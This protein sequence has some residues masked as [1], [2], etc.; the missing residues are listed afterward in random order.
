MNIAILGYG[1]EGHA[2]ERYFKSHNDTDG[3]KNEIT[4]YNN[5]ARENL[6][7]LYTST[8]RGFEMCEKSCI[9][10]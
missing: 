7:N 5:F 8:S 2:A 1:V 3:N 4:V 9:F 6:K 10:A